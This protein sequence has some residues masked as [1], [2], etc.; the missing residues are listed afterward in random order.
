[1][2][3]ETP[4]PLFLIT[5]D[6]TIKAVYLMFGIIRQLFLNRKMSRYGLQPPVF[7]ML[8]LVFALKIASQ[9]SILLKLQSIKY[10]FCNN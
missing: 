9:F 7:R 5:K 2:G 4:S 3:G 6:Q 10:L 1:M 8:L